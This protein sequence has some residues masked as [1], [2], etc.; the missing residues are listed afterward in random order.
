MILITGASGFLGLHLTRVLVES[1]ATVRSLGRSHSKRLEK[2]G[3]EQVLGTVTER[4]DVDRALAGVSA[5]YHL[6]GAVTRDKHD[7]GPVYQVHVRGTQ[8][9][10]QGCLDAGISQVLVLST[11][12]TIGVST[13]EYTASE[14]D[15]IQWD[16]IKAWPYYESK[17]YAELEVERF[18]K[19]G[20][21]VKMARPTLLLGPGDY[22]MS[23]TGDVVKFLSGKVTAALPGG[24][25][26]V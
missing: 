3:V 4:E 23:S 5:V 16:I 26:F 19:L 24:V 20:L 17:A 7:A 13:D 18:V 2:L 6:A 9:V 8:N 25:S 15:P 11:S 14:D 12:G 22:G 21:P 1:G 10:L